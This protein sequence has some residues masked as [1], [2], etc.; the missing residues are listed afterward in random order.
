MKEEK[1]IINVPVKKTVILKALTWLTMSIFKKWVIPGL[2]F[3][4]FSVFQTNNTNIS[5]KL[6]WK[7]PS[8]L[9]YWDSNSHRLELQSPCP[10]P[11][12]QGSRPTFCCPICQFYSWNSFVFKCGNNK[13]GTP[14]SSNYL[15][16]AKPAAAAFSAQCLPH[17]WQKNRRQDW[18]TSR[19][20]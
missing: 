9:W 14:F 3:H 19:C 15:R 7:C 6:M 17:F 5:N 4:L 10:I 16:S 12:D 8:S 13:I 11:L 1:D 18:L 2:F 20:F